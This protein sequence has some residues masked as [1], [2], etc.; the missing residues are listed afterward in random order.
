MGFCFSRTAWKMMSGPIRR[1]AAWS[2]IPM[3]ALALLS[4]YRT[5]GSMAW[6][7]AFACVAV[8]LLY[9]TYV[10]AG[11]IALVYG[12]QPEV[13]RKIVHICVGATIV[14]V[15]LVSA[16]TAAVVSACTGIAVWQVLS[17]RFKGPSLLRSLLLDRP[18]QSRG[19]GELLMPLG[20]G[21]SFLVAG[22]AT[23]SWLY[24]SLVLILADAAAAIVGT[25]WARHRYRIAG[26]ASVKSLEGSAAFVAA[27]WF[28]GLVFL[29]AESD[30]GFWMAMAW[31]LLL[32]C[33]LAACEAVC[34]RGWDNFVLP[35]VAVFAASL[36]GRT[37][38]LACLLI[39]V[40]V[41]ALA[42]SWP[43]PAGEV[44]DR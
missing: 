40:L 2:V 35:L 43:V 11:L 27:A 24:A 25:Y 31:T 38:S 9:C 7:L 10:V 26:G 28:A 15:A 13:R 32:A 6:S 5:P 37:A 36:P 19:H 12:A 3:A 22:G 8:L 44:R 23:A 41:F 39:V 33:M 4:F 42:S 17:R 18:G 30:I 14:G 20:L 1:H 16:S 29:L 34:L 21:C